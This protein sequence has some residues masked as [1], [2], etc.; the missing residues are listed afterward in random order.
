[1]RENC[2]QS[3][4][5]FE[6]NPLGIHLQALAR[7]FMEDGYAN[8]TVR[9]KLGLLTDFGRWFGRTGFD[10]TRV[11][12]RLVGV[13]FKHRKRVWRGHRKTLEQFLAHPPKVC[14]DPRS[15]AG[16]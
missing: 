14:R 3:N 16:A 4:E 15:R 10:A 7:S 9:L 13:F 1:M 2:L 12:E 6:D 8:E 11:D 5:R